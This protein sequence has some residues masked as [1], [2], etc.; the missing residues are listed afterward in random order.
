MYKFYDI[1]KPGDGLPPRPG[2]ERV[3][4]G[5]ASIEME[6]WS[7]SFRGFG[8][9]VSKY[10]KAPLCVGNVLAEDGSLVCGFLCEPYGLE[11]SK[12]ITSF[13]GWRA[14]MKSKQK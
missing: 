5:G 4:E 7:L 6:I 11:G 9:F 13:G 2:L 1:Q 3:Q 14:Y 8:E 10:V 12:D